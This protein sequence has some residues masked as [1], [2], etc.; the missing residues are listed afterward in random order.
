MSAQR[1]P[2]R[3][4]LVDT[5]EVARRNWLAPGRHRS[6]DRLPPEHDLAEMLGISRGTL[7]AALLRLEDTGEIVRRQGSGTFVGRVG[8]RSALDEGLERLEP[9]SSIARGRGTKL[10]VADLGIERTGASPQAAQRLSIEPGSEV[11]EISR[12]VLAD[13]RPSAKMID[14]LGPKVDVPSEAKLRKALEKGKMVLDILLGHGVPIAYATT[15]ILPR[16][17]TAREPLGRDLGI[18]RTTAVL[19]LEEVYHVTTGEV[20]YFSRDI[21]APG[22]LDLHVL[23]WLE[24]ARPEQVNARGPGRVARA[25]V[26]D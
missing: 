11:I 1:A 25:K 10:T 20:L 15:H 13:G 26:K 7:R 14:T 16:L 3:P 2:Q 21:F 17:V 4:S 12:V 8:R 18:D 24:A 22:G 19:D 5:A 23:R 9:Y 6:G